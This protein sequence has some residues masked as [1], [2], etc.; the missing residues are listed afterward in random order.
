MSAKGECSRS[1]CGFEASLRAAQTARDGLSAQRRDDVMGWLLLAQLVRPPCAIWLA[2]C[3]VYEDRLWD[4]LVGR[5]S[6]LC[7]PWL[8]HRLIGDCR[9]AGRAASSLGPRPKG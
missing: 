1:L 6:P 3:G 5:H 2:L 4:A 8:A 9:L 7:N